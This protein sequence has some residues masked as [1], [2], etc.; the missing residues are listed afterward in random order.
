MLFRAGPDGL[1]IQAVNHVIG[2]EYFQAG[3]FPAEQFALPIA[4]L[5]AC[6]SK[7]D[8]PVTLTQVDEGRKVTLRWD[9]HNVPQTQTHA[10]SSADVLE[11][12]PQLPEAWGT[13]DRR[14]IDALHSA[15]RV[16]APES[17]RFA[18]DA[19]LLRGKGGKIMATDC[20]QALV[21][22]VGFTFPWEDDVLMPGSDLFA[23]PEF[24]ADA[25]VEIGATVSHVCVRI[26]PWTLFLARV[27]DRRFPDVEGACPLQTAVRTTV[28]LSP[29]DRKFLAD[30]LPRLPA[31]RELDSPVTVDCNGH[32]ALRARGT[33]DPQVTELTLSRS[34]VAGEPVRLSINRKYLAQALDLGFSQLQ[35]VDANSPLICAD[36]ERTYFWMSLGADDALGPTDNC[37][38]FDSQNDLSAPVVTQTNTTVLSSNHR[39]PQMRRVSHGQPNGHSEQESTN[40]T[41]PGAESTNGSTNGSHTSAEND[42]DHGSETVPAESNDPLAAA[43]TLQGSLREALVNTNRLLQILRRNRKQARLVESTLASLRQLQSV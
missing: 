36:E 20:R 40:G 3:E 10:E 19:I 41:A 6:E 28:L 16:A 12:W 42:H 8:D 2:V 25:S 1:R 37:V 15:G 18:T 5:A 26:G 33:D 30:S 22:R 31:Q 43:E 9:D 24:P 17:Q 29:D 35:V 27:T 4:P 32:V 14:F 7:R 21:C 38:R 34:Q 13:T 11:V 23:F 39:S